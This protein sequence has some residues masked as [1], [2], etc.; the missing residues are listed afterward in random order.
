MLSNTR[1]GLASFKEGDVK[2]IK[3]KDDRISEGAPP[4]VINTTIEKEPS[5]NDKIMPEDGSACPICYEAPK[6]N[7]KNSNCGHKACLACWKNWLSEQLTCPLCRVR[8]RLPYLE[9]CP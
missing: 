4:E 2:Q 9:P 8:C 5:G 3:F 7:H 6:D 1:M